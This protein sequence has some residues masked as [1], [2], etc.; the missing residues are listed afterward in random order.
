MWTNTRKGLGMRNEILVNA[1]PRETRV[2][3]RE[4]DQAVELYIERSTERGVG[5]GIY[6]G[7]VTRVLPGM[8]AAFVDIGLERAGFLYVADYRA[9]LDDVDLED[10]ES[11]DR[12]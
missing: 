9:D 7:R 11:N 8:Q 2:A 5:G 12:R 3:V 10:D 1:G 6:K 4:S